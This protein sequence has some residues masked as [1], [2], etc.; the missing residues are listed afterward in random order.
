MEPVN[1]SAEPTKPDPSQLFSRKDTTIIGH[2]FKTLN[3]NNNS[4]KS[5]A[6]KIGIYIN[7]C[8]RFDFRSRLF[9]RIEK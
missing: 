8:S 5:L 7:N 2:V 4:L 3:L 1:T 9:R 6:K